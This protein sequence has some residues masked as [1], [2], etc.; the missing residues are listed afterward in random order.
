MTGLKIRIKNEKEFIEIQEK[1][2]ENGGSWFS[3]EENVLTWEDIYEA[4]YGMSVEYDKEINIGFANPPKNLNMTFYEEKCDYEDDE[5]CLEISFEDF[6]KIENLENYI[7][8][9]K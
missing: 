5:S 4:P 7:R 6:M 1:V 9:L 3:S 2:F 8:N